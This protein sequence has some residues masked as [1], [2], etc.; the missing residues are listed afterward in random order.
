MGFAWEMI[1][2][3]P[4]W[5]NN[6]TVD[7]SDFSST[8]GMEATPYDQALQSLVDFYQQEQEQTS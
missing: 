8:F 2:M 4:F 7:D 3:M 6:Y 5:T 1:E